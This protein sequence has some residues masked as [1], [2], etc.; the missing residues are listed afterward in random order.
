MEA[1]Q[2]QALVGND[3]LSKTNA[4]LD[5]NTQKLQ[6]SQNRQHMC[7]SATCGHFKTTN[8][9]AP[10][11][12]FEEEKPKSTW[13]AYQVSWADKEHNELPPILS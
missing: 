9:I 8:T 7:I 12:D 1:T 4:T 2:Y 10:L 6:L 3:W 11:I 5:W 13:E